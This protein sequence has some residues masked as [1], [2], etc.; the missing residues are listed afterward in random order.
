MLW[1]HA[2]QAPRLAEERLK[3]QQ[4]V[5]LLRQA[6]RVQQQR[7]AVRPEQLQLALQASARAGSVLKRSQTP[8]STRWG[9]GDCA[10]R[11]GS[12]KVPLGRKVGADLHAGGAARRQPLQ[13]VLQQQVA[14][15][16]ALA[17]GVV[18]GGAAAPVHLRQG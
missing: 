3:Q 12:G 6:A 13:K 18:D 15:V 5:P 17:V 4:P 10:I 11:T 1:Q 8:I 7:A 9:S 14:V 16:Q 2:L